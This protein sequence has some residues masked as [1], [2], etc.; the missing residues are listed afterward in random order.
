[1]RTSPRTRLIALVH[2]S[3]VTGAV[4]PLADVGRVAAERDQ[5]GA[6][7]DR[8][9]HLVGV[10]AARAVAG[11]VAHANVALVGQESEWTEDRIVLADGRYH[12]IAR[13]QKAQ[14]RRV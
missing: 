14:K 9:A 5:A 1:V 7:R 6:G 10:D 12:V 11:D 2:V 13:P 4:Q 8:A 3:N